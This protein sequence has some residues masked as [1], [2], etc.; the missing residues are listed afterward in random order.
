[1]TEERKPR[2]NG[3][4]KRAARAGG[5]E[6]RA[7]LAGQTESRLFRVGPSSNA[8]I[9]SSS[10]GSDGLL[11]V[12]GSPIVYNRSYQVWDAYG[13][14]TE[15]MAPTV[16]SAILPTC[17]CRFLFNHDGLPLARTTSGTLRLMNTPTSLDFTA[18]LDPRQSL[19]ND[20]R[21]ALQRADITSMSC[22]FMVASDQW[23]E[24][25]SQ[26]TIF[27]FG[28]LLDVS[29]VTYRPPDHLHRTAGRDPASRR[30]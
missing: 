2:W 19:A 16:V 11:T 1:M 6:R 3:T 20:L 25:F 10:V 29:A 22:S 14:F 5:V 26:R 17:D 4:D 30:S 23:N 21:I 13:S 7:E 15:T 27:T 24:D 12:S 8:S 9:R 28:E 18:E